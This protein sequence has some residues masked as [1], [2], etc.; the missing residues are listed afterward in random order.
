MHPKKRKNLGKSCE[1]DCVG[2]LHRTEPTSDA[3]VTYDSKNYL[4]YTVNSFFS[5]LSLRLDLPV[6][7]TL[8]RV[9]E[10]FLPMFILTFAS[11]FYLSL[12]IL[13]SPAH[14]RKLEASNHY[15]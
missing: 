5:Y 6:K 11:H 8:F 4:S 10:A 9:F 3:F 2:W 13:L 1:R 15:I 12:P 14:F 7:R